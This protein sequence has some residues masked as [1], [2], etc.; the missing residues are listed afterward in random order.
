M[1]DTSVDLHKILFETRETLLNPK[2]Y[3]ASMPLKGGFAEPV[4]KAVIYGIA[5]GLFSLL[6]SLL[7]LS[8]T[9]GGGALGGAAGLMALFWSILGS[10][11]AV[12]IGGAVMFVI[13]AAC[14]GNTDFEANLRVASSLMAVYPINA[15]L[16]FFYGINFALG[17]VVGLAMSLYSIYLTY[18]AVIEALKGRESSAKI[19]AIVL[20]VFA[21]IGFYG[22]RE[23][24]NYLEDYSDT[25]QEE[26]EF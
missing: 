12:F 4:I 1:N 14:G 9:I 25:F 5:A 19:A 24:N 16:S 26:Q 18:H 3:F 21:L 10:V 11:V 6:W 8:A 17:G 20:V 13:S 7:G 15:F 2:E 22:G 23:V